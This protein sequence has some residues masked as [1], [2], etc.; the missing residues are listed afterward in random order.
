MIQEVI[1]PKLGQTMEEGTINKWVK[2]EGEYVKK[3]EILLEVT[4]DKATLEVESYAAGILKK[5][6]A[7]EGEVVPVTQV[8]AYIGD[9]DDVVPEVVPKV[10]KVAEKEELREGYTQPVKEAITS[11]ETRGTSAWAEGIKAIS[12][13]ARRLAREKGVDINKVIGT[14]PEGRIVEE[15]ILN[16]LKTGEGAKVTKPPKGVPLTPMRKII[17]SRMSKSKTEA[18]HFYITTEMDMSK[19][20]AMREALNKDGTKVSYNDFFAKAVSL[21]ILENKIINSVWRGDYVEERSEINIGIAVALSDGLI[22]PVIKDVDKKGLR[23]IARDSIALVD[24]ARKN[25]LTPDE[26]QGGSFTI[27]NL[28]TFDVDNFIAII[29][30]GE[31]AILAIGKIAMRPIV[32]DGKIEVRPIC[33]V[34]LSCDHRV[35][36]GAVAA[37]FLQKVKELMEDAQGL[38]K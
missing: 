30:P 34:T 26:Y 4:T 10:Q 19:C 24:K 21:S 14:G 5:I 33:K 23:D 6:I 2:K 16:Y 15:D 38:E 7:K 37:K 32:I 12:P 35:L 20:M 25:K 36:D 13:R 3:G 1:M 18:P 22:V 31:S 27:S 29:N 28:G 9:K 8:I 11:P 17:A